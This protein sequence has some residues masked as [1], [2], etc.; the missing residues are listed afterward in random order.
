M[1]KRS[2]RDGT[3]TQKNCTKK[4]Q[5]NWIATMVWSATQSQTSEEKVKWALGSTAG[6]KASGCEG[7]PIELFK[8]L[9]DDAIKVLHSICQQSGR[10][11]SGHRT[12]KG[13]SSAQ[14]PRRV[15]IKNIQTIRQLHARL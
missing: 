1:L 5:M 14:F 6:N 12:G 10:P 7:I 4:I 3:D 2:R 15:V 13:Q 8:T 9:K 11:S